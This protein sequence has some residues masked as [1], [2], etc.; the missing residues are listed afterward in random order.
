M[1]K[2]LLTIVCILCISF[3]NAQESNDPQKGQTT[4]GFKAGL[5]QSYLNTSSDN[6]YEGLELYAGFFAETSL[7]KKWSFQY[8]L[9]YSY[10]DDINFLEIPLL[11]KYHLNDKLAFMAGPK[12]DVVANKSIEGALYVPLSVSFSLGVQYNISRHFFVEGR[13][14]LGLSNELITNGNS[15]TFGR[16]TL[17]LGIGLKF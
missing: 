7:S 8:E 17:R 4:F 6:G 2:H 1:K 15:E 14:G 16:N 10:T 11:F 5:N 13:Y 3:V 12:L 9:L